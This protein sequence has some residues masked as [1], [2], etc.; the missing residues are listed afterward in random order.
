MIACEAA[1][2]IVINYKCELSVRHT[3]NFETWSAVILSDTNMPKCAYLDTRASQTSLTSTSHHSGY[4]KK[5]KTM[6]IVV[7]L[8]FHNEV[9]E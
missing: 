4:H 6:H 2:V 8:K 7:H 9:K 5:R 1:S 3:Y